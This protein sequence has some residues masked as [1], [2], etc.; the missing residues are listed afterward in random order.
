ME[1][2]TDLTIVIPYLNP[3]S[4]LQSHI[5]ELV[6]ILDNSGLVYELIAVSDGSTDGS[7]AAINGLYPKVLTNVELG[8]NYGKGHAL[9]TGFALGKGKYIGFIDGDGDIPAVNINSVVELIKTSQPEMIIGSKRHPDS[10]VFYPFLRRA[11]S[12]GFQALTSSLFSIDVMD[13][14]TGFKVVR[15]DVILAVLPLMVEE[16]FALDLEL[17]VI[18]KKLGYREIIEVPVIINRRM[19]STVSL[20]AVVGMLLDTLRI[21]I[22]SHLSRSNHDG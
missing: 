7:F 5:A 12:W 20:K 6:K 10:E 11:Y 22:R 14:Q 21:Y 9:R 18:A 16:R 4:V 17:L 13:T 15:R 8:R 2:T 3:G 19:T 1:V